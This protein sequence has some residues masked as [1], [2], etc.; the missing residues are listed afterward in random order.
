MASSDD[1]PPK[2]AFECNYTGN[3]HYAFYVDSMYQVMAIIV[4]D[5]S[6]GWK[7]T[8]SRLTLPDNL[9]K[10]FLWTILP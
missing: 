4:S 6:L 1:T 10:T 8:D 5:V 2:D 9:L 3:Q 7:I